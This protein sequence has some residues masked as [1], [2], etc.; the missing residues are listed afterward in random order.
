M[1]T[2]CDELIYKYGF[3]VESVDSLH[4]LAKSAGNPFEALR[5][6]SSYKDV[7]AVEKLLEEVRRRKASE[8]AMVSELKGEVE[9]LR[10]TRDGIHS[11]I[12][13]TT[14][15]IEK[16][17]RDY[18][19]TLTSRFNEFEKKW[20]CMQVEVGKLER[21]LQLARDLRLLI[22]QPSEANRLPP[23]HIPTL[24]NALFTL[25]GAKGFNPPIKVKKD[26]DIGSKV[27]TEH[28]YT[29]YEVP[30]QTLLAW[31]RKGIS[32]GTANENK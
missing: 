14:S 24:L 29:H 10:A 20:T 17:F 19:D 11:S 8:E 13:E 5:A 9:R 28:P 7:K 12:S 25:C 6:I 26:D 32:A 2:L 22:Y 21:D 18:A 3:S 27:K 16:S 30:L 1:M 15:T 4:R 23:D 31:A